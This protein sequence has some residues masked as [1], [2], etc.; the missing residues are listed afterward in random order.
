[1]T[2][3]S[4]PLFSFDARGRLGK[5]L[6]LTKRRGVNITQKKPVP[7]QPNTS[8]QLA[9]RGVWQDGIAQWHLLAADEKNSYESKARPYHMTGFA[10][11]MRGYMK[12]NYPPPPPPPEEERYEYYLIG[13]DGASS[14]YTIN[15]AAQ[16]FAPLISHKITKVIL[17]LHRTAE[18]I[19][20]TVEIR[21]TEGDGSPSDNILCSKTF[22]SEPI[23]QEA[24]GESYE[25]TFAVPAD[26][27]ADIL[28]AIVL[29][30]ETPSVNAR[31]FWHRDGTDPTYPRGQLWWSTTSGD[32]F[33]GYPGMDYLF[34]E[35]GIAI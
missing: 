18:F 19:D 5:E 6:N 25:L 31:L 13:D 11:F 20:F 33:T 7:R 24:T 35:W 10:Y 15:Y 8:G 29:Y 3:V 34:E 9:V 28:Y 2:K 12:E 17:V 23:T 21:T 27:P 32:S 16:T 22:S 26:L 30:Q 4:N 14:I 1:M